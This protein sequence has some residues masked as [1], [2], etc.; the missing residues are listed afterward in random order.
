MQYWES[1]PDDLKTF[2]KDAGQY[3]GCGGV[4]KNCA[5]LHSIYPAETEEFLSRY[6][7]LVRKISIKS[8][9]KVGIGYGLAGLLISLA[10]LYQKGIG[11]SEI[12]EQVFIN[13]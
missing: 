12:L 7:P 1:K 3:S 6:L 8:A 11:K 13:D 10:E 9:E 4:L 2:F 5:A